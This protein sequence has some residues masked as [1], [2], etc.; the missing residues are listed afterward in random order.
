M[1]PIKT[2]EWLIANKHQRN[3]YYSILGMYESTE[4]TWI[5]SLIL[6]CGHEVMTKK[7]TKQN[8]SCLLVATRI[9]RNKNK[10]ISLKRGHEI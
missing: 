3:I 4:G 10:K 8:K 1:L 6:S 2:V 7:K 9:T 5:F